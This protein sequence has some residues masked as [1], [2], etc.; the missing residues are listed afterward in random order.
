M[1]PKPMAELV[2][3]FTPSDRVNIKY[4]LFMYPTCLPVSRAE[5]ELFLRNRSFLQGTVNFTRQ[6]RIYGRMRYLV[7]TTVVTDCPNLLRHQ[8]Q[9]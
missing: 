1:Q 4:S 7:D 2:G 3:P 5:M 9:K 8:K 6:N